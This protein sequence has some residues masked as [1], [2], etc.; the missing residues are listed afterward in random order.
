MGSSCATLIFIIFKFTK[1]NLFKKNELLSTICQCF[2]SWDFFFKLE[3]IIF[4]IPLLFY[5][6]WN[7]CK[8]FEQYLFLNVLMTRFC[9]RF[10]KITQK[11]NTKFLQVFQ[12]FDFH[13]ILKIFIKLAFFFR[14][15]FCI[16]IQKH[17]L[18]FFFIKYFIG[19]IC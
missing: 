9:V 4:S 18:W 15:Y 5:T 10:P 3:W 14:V 11:K 2:K 7:S 8:L 16:A 19:D 17:I 13:L 1:W 12:M 6:I